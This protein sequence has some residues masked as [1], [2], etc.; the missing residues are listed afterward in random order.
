MAADLAVIGAKIRTLD[1]ERPWATA[2]AVKDGT[3]V[4]V[5]DDAA[6]RAECDAKTNVIDGTGMHMVPGLTDAHF[7]PFHGTDQEIGADLTKV[8]TLD[9][10]RAALAAERAKV[11]PDA[12]VRGWGLVFEV[13]AETGIR[14]D[15]F[16]DAID[17]AP[18]L[19]MFFD[20]HNA[21]ATPAA[22]ALC[23]V[24]GHEVFPD[25]STVVVD[26]MGAPTGELQ[27][28]SAMNLV[29]DRIPARTPEQKRQ[30]YVANMKI[31]NSLGLT[32]LHAM[33]GKPHFFDLLRDLEGSGDLSLRMRI[34]LW[35]E[36]EMTLDEMR[37][38]LPYRNER[39]RRWT[40]GTAKFF[41][42][43]TIEG[44]TAWLI[45]PDTEGASHTPY[46]PDPAHYTAAVDCF[47]KGG[48][49]CVT[50]AVGDMAVR[51]ALD[52]YEA[53]GPVPG[54]MHR[55]EHIE[56]LQDEDLPRFAKLGVAASMQPLHMAM[57]DAAGNDEW[58]RRVGPER[59][60][61][62]F[63]TRDLIGSGA[64]LAL[65]SDWGVAPYDPRLGM[66]WCRLRRTPGCPE[67]GAIEPRQAL[68]G[69]Q[70]LA[71]YTTEA[72]KV[73][74]DES[75]AGKIKEGYRAD[76]SAFAADLVDTP[77]DDLLHVPT[78]LTVVD[79][80]VMFQAE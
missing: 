29:R 3:I 33:I 77:P 16:A 69:L 19:L 71:G 59:R 65:G 27:E 2:V 40:G 68:T 8:R 63:R 18:A 13:F 12:W 67:K 56:V 30:A 55:V 35:A 20:F 9:E 1:P 28:M 41:I 10:L 70:T 23:G 80:E 38:W 57:F 60:K 54:A 17:G 24:T 26:E 74:G 15:L 76:L 36:P 32:G 79:G 42:D 31:W 7:H 45:E 50:H 78:R 49:Q 53:A 75:V 44:G 52:A 61:L 72:A 43:G 4:A 73:V 25:F 48:F 6:I 39:G 14:G 62:A 64:T 51:H 11:G 21:V 22:L 46:W 5:G 58:S 47:A 34:P 66:A 37:A